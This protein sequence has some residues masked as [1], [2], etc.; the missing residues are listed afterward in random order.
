[1]DGFEEP[2]RSWMYIS[3]VTAR[4]ASRMGLKERPA[5][6]RVANGGVRE[7][8]RDQTKGWENPELL[9]DPDSLKPENVLPIIN[10]QIL[11]DRGR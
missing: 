1:V 2:L 4:D 6:T 10:F 9:T 7:H 5:M 3:P 11:A 8:W